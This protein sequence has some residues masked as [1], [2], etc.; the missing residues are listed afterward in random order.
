M[1]L[2]LVA[3]ENQKGIFKRA[4]VGFERKAKRYSDYAVALLE[5]TRYPDGMTLGDREDNKT[6]MHG[7]MVCCATTKGTIY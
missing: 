2:S 6:H 4:L 1:Y 5:R 3:R 7:T